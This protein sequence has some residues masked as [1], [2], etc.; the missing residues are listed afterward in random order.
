MKARIIKF[1]EK[2]FTRMNN[3]SFYSLLH[4]IMVEH[5]I[6]FFRSTGI[7]FKRILGP[8]FVFI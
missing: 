1:E 8:F 5:L 4:F 2:T 3:I 7:I 6:Y